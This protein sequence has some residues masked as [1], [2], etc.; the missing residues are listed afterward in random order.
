MNK[1]LLIALG[2]LFLV[3]ALGV[4]LFAYKNIS[5]EPKT[6]VEQ[7]TT[8]NT[9]TP[10]ESSKVLKQGT[11]TDGDA[12]HKGSGTV[13]VVETSDG[14]VLQ[15]GENFSVTNGPDL[16]VYIS[17]QPAGEGLGDFASLGELKKTSGEQTYT[18]PSNYSEY[19]SVVIWCR[20]FSVE[21]AIASLE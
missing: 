7:T 21:F 3:V 9:V 13:Q 17:K 14:P 6:V 19:K 11:F 16:F 4:G 12:V 1:K 2:A 8:T 20:A 10:T 15:F 18:L 5:Q